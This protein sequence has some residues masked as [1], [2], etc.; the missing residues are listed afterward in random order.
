MLNLPVECWGTAAEAVAAQSPGCDPN[1]QLDWSYAAAA[2]QLEKDPAPLEKEATPLEKEV[3]PLASGHERDSTYAVSFGWLVA[4][5]SLSV[6]VEQEPWVPQQDSLLGSRGPMDRL[7]HPLQAQ[8][9]HLQYRNDF[10]YCRL[11]N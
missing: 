6:C 5:Q 4:A 7:G 9:F 2:A 8:C 3:T 11:S 10:E 1:G